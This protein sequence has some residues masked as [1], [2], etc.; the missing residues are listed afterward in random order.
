MFICVAVAMQMGEAL[1]RGFIATGV[2]TPDKICA[3]VRSESRQQALEPL[4]ITTYGSALG[5]G[6]AKLAQ[7]SDIIFLAVCLQT[8]PCFQ[9]EASKE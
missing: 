6:A 5:K 9:G 2:S 3:C 1:I 7:N 8:I 4:G